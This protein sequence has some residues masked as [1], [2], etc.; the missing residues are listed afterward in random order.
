MRKKWSLKTWKQPGKELETVRIKSGNNALG[1]QACVSCKCL[2]STAGR[3]NWNIP[4]FYRTTAAPACGDYLKWDKQ[5]QSSLLCWADV[6]RL[7]QVKAWELV[8]VYTSKAVPVFQ[9]EGWCVLCVRSSLE[10][11]NSIEPNTQQQQHLY[12][13]LTVNNQLPCRYTC[14]ST[15][16]HNWS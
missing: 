7:L 2:R 14:M 16:A 12:V 15:Y 13:Y 1:R 5:R 10:Q 9:S 8:V 11:A 6:F 3:P 4:L